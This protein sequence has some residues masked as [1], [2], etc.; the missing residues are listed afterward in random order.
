MIS[1]T[2]VE[3]VL[4]PEAEEAWFQTL[5]PERQTELHAHWQEK[6][7]WHGAYRKRRRKQL[8]YAAL[9]TGGLFV[10]FDQL[11]FGAGWGSTLL[12]FVTGGLLGALL[13]RLQAKQLL[14]GVLAMVLFFAVQFFDGGRSVFQAFFFTFA[15]GAISAVA[16]WKRE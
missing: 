13:L 7:D 15:L 1:Q 9:E 3:P 16:S 5:P 8:G 14:S 11:S 10:L 12:C 2:E 6:G 4:H